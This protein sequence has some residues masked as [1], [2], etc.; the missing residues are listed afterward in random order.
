VRAS[1]VEEPF[2]LAEW[3]V[4]EGLAE[5]F[6]VEVC[7]PESTGAWYSTVTGKTLDAVWE[8]VMAAF[9]TGLT[10]RDWT[11][12]VLGDVVGA[13][14]GLKPVGVPH[15]GGYAV[16]R[17][18]VENYLAATGLKAAQVMVRPA[19]EIIERAGAKASR[20]G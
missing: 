8:K 14:M 13:R 7:G 18:I 19:A 15:M 3:I 20:S 12:F 1:N 2:D 4:H 16:G 9:G 11:P 6:T 5:V 10:F 17:R